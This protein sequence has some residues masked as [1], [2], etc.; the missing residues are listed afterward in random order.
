MDI[1]T[2][3]TIGLKENIN[4]ADTNKEHKLREACAG[5][6]A[7]MLKQMLSLARK[8]IPKSGLWDGGHAE[9]IYQSMHDDLL[10]Q[11]LAAGE[12]MGFGEL[13][14]RQLSNTSEQQSK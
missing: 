7:L 11:R 3:A 6:E 4:S 2:A 13:L 14:Y 12:G 9:E 1:M 10:T 5:F 8:S